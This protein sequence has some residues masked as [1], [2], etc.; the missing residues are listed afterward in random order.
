MT[1]DT[2]RLQLNRRGFLQSYARSTGTAALFTAVG[3]SFPDG[4]F[5]QGDG[6]DT[7]RA[8]LGFLA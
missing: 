5:A 6:P 7:T 3:V 2:S 1:D 4:V 8:V